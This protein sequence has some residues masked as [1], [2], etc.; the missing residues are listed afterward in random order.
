MVRLTEGQSLDVEIV[1]TAEDGN[2]TKTYTIKMRRLSAD[3]ATLSQLE[4]SV[5]ALSP[6]F[7]P[8]IYMYECNLHCSIDSL[9]VKVKTEEDSMK[10]SM[11]DGSPVGTIQLNPGRTLSV[12]VV[13]SANGKNNAEYSIVFS[14]SALPPTLQLKKGKEEFECAVCCGVVSRSAHIDKGPY[15]YCQDCLEELTRTN[16][17][18]PF[19][20]KNL[21]EEDWMKKDLECD[22]RLG[23]E[24]AVCPLPNGQVEGP[25]KLMGSKLKT[26]AKT[27]EDMVSNQLSWTVQLFWVVFL[28]YFLGGGVTTENVWYF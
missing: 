6:P 8:F 14:K 26:A 25:V 16:K 28:F 17:M 18:D 3:D 24:E 22:S 12:V 2:T 1:V 15:T 27:I 10:V 11:K 4:V 7:S 9:S 5:G 13:H 19:T 21:S 23:L 20:G